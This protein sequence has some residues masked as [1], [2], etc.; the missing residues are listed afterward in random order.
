VRSDT[1]VAIYMPGSDYRA[2]AQSLTSAGL[3]AETPCMLISQIG[4]PG[5]RVHRSTLDRV[6]DLPHLPAPALFLAGSAVA[7]RR[8]AELTEERDLVPLRH[9]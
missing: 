2:L 4:C 3:D 9:V 5:Q 6:G 7:G 8:R 1:T